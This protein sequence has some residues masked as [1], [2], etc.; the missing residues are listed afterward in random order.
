MSRIRFA[1]AAGVAFFALAANARAAEPGAVK[2]LTPDARGFVH[3][4]VGDIW[5]ADIAKQ[6]RAFAAQ[7]GPDLLAEFN[8]GFY[9]TPSEVESFTVILF[10]AKFRDILPA[11]RPTDVTPVWVITSK[12]PLA[13][14][15]L[16]K[17]MA[18]TGKPRKHAGKDYYFDEANWSGLL[19]LDEHSYAYAS[20][21]SITK[22]ID[23][24][25]KG[26]ES[27]LAAT[28]AREG[29]K[30]PVTVGV[31]VA[32]LATP[33]MLKGM[34]AELQPLFKAKAMVATLDVKSKTALAVALE[35]GTAAEAKD[36]Q[37]AVQEAVQFGR[38]QIGS[39]LTF[40][41]QKA[42]RK[43]G[44]PPAGIQQ[45][46]EAVGL[47]LASAGLKQLDTLLGAMPITAKGNSVH[48]TLELD[49]I[50]PGG[51]TAISIAV[52]ATAIG[53]AIENADRG[54]SRSFT[55]A[56][57]DWSE[58]ERNLA[59]VAKA[60]EKYR[61]DKGH[62]PPPAI[63]DKDGKP[64]LSWRVAILPYMDNVYINTSVY[65]PGQRTPSP[66]ELY[67]MFKLDEPWDGPNNKKLID[68][69]P[70]AYRAPWSV[71]SYS[72]SSIG[73]TMTLAVVSKGGIF[74]AT[75]KTVS[76]SDVRDGLKQTLLLLQLEEAGHAVYWTKP[77][78]IH[79][80]PDGKLPADG[81]N[82]ARRFAVVYADTSAHTLVNGLDVKT[83][84]GI[85]TRDGSE[86]LD[87]KT[88]RPESIKPKNAPGGTEAPNPPP[89]FP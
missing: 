11:G 29:E 50:L 17:T 76:D 10:D 78:D 60:I 72:Q 31:N 46:P 81:P 48:A 64:T 27:P 56:S 49:S 82:F 33:A 37:K 16:L 57:Y 34:P 61:K 52:V 68:K 62:Y 25:A 19:I 79:L 44:T 9:P 86:K 55:S 21:D 69:F 41:E 24:M 5:T 47:I 63:L 84:L 73:K 7:A 42:R 58:R 83:L 66:K 20:E 28:L 74:D 85:V 13:R 32:L 71:L 59:T 35:F 15:E 70:S 77:A 2:L 87:E 45:F 36:G 54:Q 51:S 1:L 53:V 26:G 38:G 4:R 39:A 14:A 3:V 8:D 80:T 43:P 22:L 75:K 40:V 6:L 12:K 23:R 18:K 30:H 65:E 67:E 88:I 89:L